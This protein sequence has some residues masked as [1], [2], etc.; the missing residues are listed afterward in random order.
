[1]NLFKARKK[2]LEIAQGQIYHIILVYNS[3]YN[4]ILTA[5]FFAIKAQDTYGHHY[6]VKINRI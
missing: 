4:H 3:K 2:G 6:S 5:I 1:M